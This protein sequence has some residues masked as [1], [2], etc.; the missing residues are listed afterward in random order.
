VGIALTQR[1]PTSCFD[2]AVET[3]SEA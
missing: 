1:T 3:C 2:K